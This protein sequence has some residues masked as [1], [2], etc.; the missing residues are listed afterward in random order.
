MSN[1]KQFKKNSEKLTREKMASNLSKAIT[2]AKM[3]KLARKNV[4]E[5]KKLRS[6]SPMSAEATV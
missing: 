3:P 4:S 6:M 2:D 1:L 5:L